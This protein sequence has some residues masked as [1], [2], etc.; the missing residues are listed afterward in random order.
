[1]RPEQES[2][3]MEPFIQTIPMSLDIF[4]S[5]PQKK[6]SSPVSKDIGNIIGNMWPF[7]SKSNIQQL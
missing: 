4:P 7:K 5:Q 3:R 1:M 6:P 2:I